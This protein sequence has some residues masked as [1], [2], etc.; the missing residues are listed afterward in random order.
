M[1]GKSQGS[2]KK[3]GAVLASQE[4]KGHANRDPYVIQIGLDFGTAY[5]KCVCRD[6]I[7]NKAWVCIPDDPALAERP[8]LMPSALQIKR[9]NLCVAD[10]TAHYHAGGL[11]HI[12]TALV[13]IA[14][15]DTGALVLQPYRTALRHFGGTALDSFVAACG[16]YLLSGILALIRRNVSQ[17]CPGFGQHPQDY[18]AVNVAIPVADAEKPKVND[19][20]Q[21]IVEAS[22]D[23]SKRFPRFVPWPLLE[24]NKLLR[25]LQ[26]RP[27]SSNQNSCYIY[28][29]VSANMQGFVR[30]RVS[31]P[32]ICIFSDTGA[33]TVDQ[34]VFIFVR[35][36]G[37]KNLLTYLYAQVLPLGSSQIE[38]RAA[39]ASGDTS[40]KVLEHWRN[41]KELGHTSVA[42][43][44]VI[45]KLGR[46]LREG[47]SATLF[48]AKKKLNRVEQLNDISV[49]FGGGGHIE[50]PYAHCV[51]STFTDRR[52][53]GSY[54]PEPDIVGLP[55]PR[56]LELPN[57]SWMKRLWVAY[58]LSFFKGDLADHIYPSNV[59]DPPPREVRTS[60]MNEFITQEM[61]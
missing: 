29:E 19:L 31:R 51:V 43:Q 61:V 6:I 8:F 57:A 37:K 40:W 11:P 35:K 33:G 2:T 25:L 26:K 52:V 1:K 5:C 15:G 59:S 30:S 14:L 58:G 22:F 10:P 38:R 42:F 55:T 18:L 44:D 16:I 53:F 13:A 45:Y 28:P 24:L 17:K 9:K 32:G 54:R 47:T 4:E 21:R 48:R 39:E 60:K 34:S 12:K 49:L 50:N 46:E 36:R 7:T 27:D 20:F 41:E 3:N 56:D 23:C